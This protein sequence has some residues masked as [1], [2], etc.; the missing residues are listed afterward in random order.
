MKHRIVLLLAPALMLLSCIKNN[1]DPSWIEIKEWTLEENPNGPDAGE[2]TSNFKNAWVYVNDK[3]MG[4]FELPCKLPVLMSGSANIKIYPAILNNGISATKKVYPFMEQHEVDVTLVQNEVL[5]I[6]PVTH[7]YSNVQFWIEDFEDPSYKLTHSTNST[8]DLI[9][10]YDSSGQNRYARIL[11]T[12]NANYWA[13]YT[14]QALSF[15]I[16][17]EVYLEVDYYNTNKIVTGLVAAKS[18]G[19]TQTHINIAMQAQDPSTVQWKKIYIDL[20]ELVGA[21]GG[22]E[23]LQ[24]FEASLDE[25]DTEGLILIDN[26]KVVHY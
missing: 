7:Y 22:V 18:D 4:V 25:G 11:L 16:G 12:E 20:K 1:P 2:L 14:N 24:W 15:P 3:L 19:S 23:F 21:S 5:T 6:N 9:P 8:T 13:A 10:E 26:I 17:T